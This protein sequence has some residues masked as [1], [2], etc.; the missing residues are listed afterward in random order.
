MTNQQ[1]PTSYTAL[2]LLNGRR[3]EFEVAI[4]AIGQGATY[5]QLENGTWIITD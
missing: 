2:Y 5:R 3:V 1:L 4:R